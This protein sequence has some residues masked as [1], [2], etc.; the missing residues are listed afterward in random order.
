MLEWISGRTYGAEELD[1]EVYREIF[2]DPTWTELDLNKQILF[3][4]GTMY[5]AIYVN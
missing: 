4:G 5:W 3:D 1:E 2:G